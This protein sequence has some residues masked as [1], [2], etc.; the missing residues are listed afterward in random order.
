M[1]YRDPMDETKDM[2]FIIRVIPPTEPILDQT[3][4]DKQL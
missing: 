1:R 2:D 3:E 4:E